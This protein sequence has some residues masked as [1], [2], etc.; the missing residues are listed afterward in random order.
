LLKQVLADDLGTA[1]NLAPDAIIL[2]AHRKKFFG[3]GKRC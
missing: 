3:A 1:L 2:I